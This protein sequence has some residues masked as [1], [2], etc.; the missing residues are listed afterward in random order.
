MLY[1]T[2]QEKEPDRCQRPRPYG[3]QNPTKQHPA[4]NGD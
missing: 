3:Q 4:A 2:I 1:Q